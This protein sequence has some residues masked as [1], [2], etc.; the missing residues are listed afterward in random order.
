MNTESL[1]LQTIS[2][3]DTYYNNYITE[4]VAYGYK[5]YAFFDNILNLSNENENVTKVTPECLIF[6]ILPDNPSIGLLKS[7]ICNMTIV[8]KIDSSDVLKIPLQLLWNLKT[9]EIIGNKLYLSLPFDIFFGDINTYQ[10]N[11]NNITFT[12]LSSND[13]EDNLISNYNLLCKIFVTHTSIT[14]YY[15]DLSDNIIQQISSVNVSVNLNEPSETSNE[16]RIRTNTFH[17]FIKGFFIETERVDDLCEIQF[18]LNNFI[19]VNFDRYLI[20]E[21]C[22]KINENIIYIPFNVECDYRSKSFISYVGS[23][24]IERIDYSFLNLKF[25]S[26]KQSVRIYALNINVYNNRN[27]IFTLSNLFST[28][29]H[30]VE[31]FHH[32]SLMPIDELIESILYS[33]INININNLYNTNNIVNIPVVDLSNNLPYVSQVLHRVINDLERNNCPITH[34]PIQANERY[35]FCSQ[36]QN[37][38]N[39]FAII[40]W[41]QVLCYRSKTC[42]SCRQIWEDYNVYI[43][44]EITESEEDVITNS[45]LV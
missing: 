24:N 7:S 38:Y 43:N 23:L 25:L 37:C 33:N 44:S 16:F 11:Q 36:C 12:L 5:K 2:N 1:T 20:K 45:L 34:S 14:R 6:T 26:Q 41:F 22:V 40:Q 29:H 42:P 10:L 30:F 31:D 18:F 17:G 21:K 39:E 9:P 28:S 4:N 8:F 3:H 15:R 13:I 27:N 35:M 32:H 19:R